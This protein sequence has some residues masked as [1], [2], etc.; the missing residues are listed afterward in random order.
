[1][2]FFLYFFYSTSR[3]VFVGHQMPLAQIKKRVA[4]SL[5]VLSAG[6]QNRRSAPGDS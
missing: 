6:A 3:A 5:C 1:M 2:H 4:H